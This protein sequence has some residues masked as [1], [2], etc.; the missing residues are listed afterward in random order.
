MVRRT[1][2]NSANGLGGNQ[3][4]ALLREHGALTDGPDTSSL[5]GGRGG[6]QSLLQPAIPVRRGEGAVGAPPAGD[7]DE[8][9]KSV[10]LTELVRAKAASGFAPNHP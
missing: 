5:L 3:L 7:P 6:R 10:D 9:A 8:I 2:H 4:P 1:Y